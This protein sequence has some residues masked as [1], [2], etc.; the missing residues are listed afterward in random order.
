M[1][2]PVRETL[3]IALKFLL[4]TKRLLFSV[5]MVLVLPK[6]SIVKD[7]IFVQSIFP[8]D[9]PTCNVINQYLSVPCKM[10]VP[11]EKSFVKM[12]RV[13]H[14]SRIALH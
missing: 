2:E 8:S 12:A 1:M 5:L 14:L 11:L 9:V 3:E 10:V 13:L 7:L 4:V 6:E